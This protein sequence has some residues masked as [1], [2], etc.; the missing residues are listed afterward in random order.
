MP[1]RAR[2]FAAFSIICLVWG[3]TFLAIRFAIESIPPFLMAAVRFL[4]A[5]LLLYPIARRSAP[6]PSAAHWRSAGI[7]GIVLFVFGN[8]F[9]TWSEQRVPS[10]IA[11]LF[12]A[13][14]PLW[15]VLI[16]WLKH[17]SSKPGRDIVAGLALGFAG[18]LLLTGNPFSGRHHVDLLGAGALLVSGF[19]WA[20]GSLY[21]RKAKL[22]DSQLLAASMEML[23]GGAALLVVATLAGEWKA[24]HPAAITIRSLVS[25]AYLSVFG[26]VIAFTAYIYLLRSVSPARVST[27]AYINPMIALLLGWAFAGEQMTPQIFIAAG[28]IIAAVILIIT[29]KSKSTAVIVTART[30]EQPAAIPLTT[31][32]V[33]RL[34]LLEHDRRSS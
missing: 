30:A 20:N 3:S 34:P 33:V 16:E 9:V 29:S 4:S 12:V 11:S 15:F 8:G 18:M 14:I 5:G 32:D 22:P 28:V 24:L 19:C 25:M 10:G 7:I 26:S 2:V 31:T 21:S 27:Y 6:R 13:M 1:N 17:G 23:C